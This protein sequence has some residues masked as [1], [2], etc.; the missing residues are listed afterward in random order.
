[1]K[2]KKENGLVSV[3]IPTITKRKQE[4]KRSL[5][6]VKNQTYKNIEIVV[7]DEG[8]AAPI[9][10][11]IGI[12]RSLGEFIAFLDDD[13]IWFPEKI[14]E[15]VALLNKKEFQD[16]GLCVTWILDK[17][18][19]TERVNKTPKVIT[20]DY[21]LDAFNLQST[22]SY[23][24]RKSH[25]KKYGGF[26]ETLP[27]AQEYDLALRLSEHNPI[28]CVPKVLV[29]QNATEGQISENWKKKIKGILAIRKKHKKNYAFSHH[30]KAFGLVVVF[31]FGFIFGNRIYSIL[32]FFKEGYQT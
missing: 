25:L 5:E 21:V 24:F 30:I 23:M 32:N 22:S 31:A 6:S 7:V 26:D 10:R 16:A 11:N 27:S 19:G 28:I 9:Q 13:D 4:L 14:E 12:K 18:F 17:R 3:V 2:E 8:L 20:H 1:M 15:Q 29:M